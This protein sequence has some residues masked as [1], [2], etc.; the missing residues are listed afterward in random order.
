MYLLDL[1]LQA[2][3]SP[4][5]LKMA[6]VTPLFKTGDPENIGSNWPISVH[7]LFSKILE[8][9]MY[10]QQAMYNHVFNYLTG[11][12]LLYKKQFCFQSDH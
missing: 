2:G 6:K 1:S 4:D 11:N 5:S 3:V 10:N 7:P 9:A 12:D 8:Q